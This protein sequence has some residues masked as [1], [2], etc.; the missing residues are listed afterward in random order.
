MVAFRLVGYTG[1]DGTVAALKHLGRRAEVLDRFI[2]AF[3]CGVA[4]AIGVAQGD[5]ESKRC[6]ECSEEESDGCHSV[7]ELKFTDNVRGFFIWKLIA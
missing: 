7:D 4:G 3:R 2:V 6:E 5:T 1:D